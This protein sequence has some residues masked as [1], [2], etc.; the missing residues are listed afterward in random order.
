ME[1]FDLLAEVQHEAADEQILAEIA[2]RKRAAKR[3]FSSVIN[4]KNLS[5]YEL[6]EVMF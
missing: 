1:N 6:D 2:T 3:S 5:K 4:Q